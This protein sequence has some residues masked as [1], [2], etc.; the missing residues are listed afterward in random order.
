MEAVGWVGAALLVAAYVLVSSGRIAGS[1]PPFQALNIA[2]G[3][4]LTLNTGYHRAWPS[5]ALNVV[6]VCVGV[7]VLIRHR[8]LVRAAPAAVRENSRV[9]RWP[10][11]D[12]RWAERVVRAAGF[13]G[14]TGGEGGPEE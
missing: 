2:G 5:A 11:P 10:C 3:V 8:T 13:A 12:R 6:W 1:G 14:V 7:G 9:Q 4:A